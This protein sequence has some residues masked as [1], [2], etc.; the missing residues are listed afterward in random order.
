MKFEGIIWKISYTQTCKEPHTPRDTQEEPEPNIMRECKL[1]AAL[2]TSQ[3]QTHSAFGGV[4]K[5]VIPRAQT[6]QVQTEVY[7]TSEKTQ[8]GRQEMT[9]CVKTSM[10]RRMIKSE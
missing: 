10:S 6:Y 9:F 5:A 2:T 4:T 3:N 8:K 7:H 1:E